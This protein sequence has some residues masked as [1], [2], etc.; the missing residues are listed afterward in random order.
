MAT[1]LGKL[2]TY[3]A[4]IPPIKS[5]KLLNTWPCEVMRKIKNV[6]S[7]LPQYRNAGEEC[8]RL[9]CHQFLVVFQILI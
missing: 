1:K 3:Y 7:P 8:K 4:K 6:I 2:V 9:I 5:K